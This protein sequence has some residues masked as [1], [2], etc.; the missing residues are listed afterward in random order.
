MSRS[1]KTRE[2]REN[3]EGDLRDINTTGDTWF[4]SESWNSKHVIGTK[5]KIWMGSCILIVILF[6]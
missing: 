6:M 2:D 3:T 5:G 4:L 1:W